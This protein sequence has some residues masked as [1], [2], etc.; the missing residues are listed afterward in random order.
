MSKT[1]L[2]VLPG[3]QSYKQNS[4]G[5]WIMHVVLL[6]S[7]GYFT[8]LIA[9]R[10]GLEC[11]TLVSHHS[12]H[13]CGHLHIVMLVWLEQCWP[14]HM[15]CVLL[16][17]IISGH[18]HV[19][20][21]RL[22]FLFHSPLLHTACLMHLVAS[23]QKLCHKV[24]QVQSPIMKA[25]QGTQLALGIM[26]LNHSTLHLAIRQTW[27][28]FAHALRRWVGYRPTHQINPP[29]YSVSVSV[30]I[31]QCWKTKASVNSYV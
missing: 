29:L 19:F 13:G 30:F 22:L 14:H 5:S 2:R 6:Q 3:L 1:W 27:P 12:W 28:V 16:G 18:A 17:I 24:A 9:D 7:A 10:Q 8:L 21:S 25:F 15:I 11:R 20:I 23:S 4:F 26:T 31:S